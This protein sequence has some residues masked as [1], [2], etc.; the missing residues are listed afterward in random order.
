[1]DPFLADE[2]RVAAIRAALPATGA[3]IFLDVASA[4]PLP[5]E[6]DR[7]LREADEWQLRV[8]RGGPDH[9][10]DAEQRRDEAS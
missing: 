8:G 9:A 3:G 10:T 4:G 2:Q 5:A 1:M 6:T 7:A